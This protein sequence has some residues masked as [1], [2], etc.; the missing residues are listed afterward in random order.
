[1]SKQQLPD[2]NTIRA[3]WLANGAARGFDSRVIDNVSAGAKVCF[4]CGSRYRQLERAHIIPHAMGGSALP[5]NL[6]LLCGECHRESPDVALPDVLIQWMND[7]C[8]DEF[9]H[10]HTIGAVLAGMP[11]HIMEAVAHMPSEQLQA[12]A[13]AVTS[14]V[15]THGCQLSKATVEW[16]VKQ[17]MQQAGSI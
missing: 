3:Y 11:A 13:E 9:R 2:A 17:T 12:I 7:R 5:D 16:M 1:M 4:C 8:N 10:L 6:L 14:Q 15:G